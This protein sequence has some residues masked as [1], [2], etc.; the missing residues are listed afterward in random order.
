MCHLAAAPPSYVQS[1]HRS[2]VG[3]REEPVFGR[4][5]ADG[6]F[7]R[8]Q[9]GLSGKDSTFIIIA[10]N[11]FHPQAKSVLVS[12]SLGL[13]AFIPNNLRM[14]LNGRISS[15]T[16]PSVIKNEPIKMAKSFSGM[17]ACHCTTK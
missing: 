16:K 15:S 12:A 4:R 2:P 17:P 5:P 14:G 6:I 7:E 11:R 9:T 8:G 1:S 13:L 3:I 10:V